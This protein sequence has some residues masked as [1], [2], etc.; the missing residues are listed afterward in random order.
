MARVFYI[1]LL[2]SLTQE[3]HGQV[4]AFL[5]KLGFGGKAALLAIKTMCGEEPPVA[6]KCK[7]EVSEIG[8]DGKFYEI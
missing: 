1:F 3:I 7:G 5:D 2:L 8:N 4:P 6:C